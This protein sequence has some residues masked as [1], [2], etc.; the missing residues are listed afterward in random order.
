MKFYYTPGSCS[1]ASHVALLETGAPFE[2]ARVVL[3]NG[4]QR[5]PEYLAINPHG[6]VPALVTETGAITETIAILTY[7]A[8]R[9]PEAR[10]LPWDRPA[11]LAR[12]YELMSWFASTVQV[13]FSQIFRGARFSDDAETLIELKAA[14]RPRFAAAL[15]ELEDLAPESG[16]LVGDAFS[17]ADAYATVFWRWAPRLELDAT[18]YPRWG[19]HAA[20]VLA[21]ESAVQAL[22]KE[23]E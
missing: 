23:A 16:W 8:R 22:K 6:R 5:K 14:G 13:S 12:A 18:A 1:F 19:A 3:A 20:R 2:T 21:R 9:F 10:L 17:V 11:E 7:L 15:A 4:D